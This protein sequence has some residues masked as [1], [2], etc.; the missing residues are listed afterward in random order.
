M[1]K[2]LFIKLGA[3]GDV[4]MALTALQRRLEDIPQEISWVCGKTVEPLIH[5]FLPSVN[6]FSLDE[7]KLFQA[8]PMKAMQEIIRVNWNLKGQKFDRIVVGYRDPRYRLFTLSARSKIRKFFTSIP[9]KYHAD[10]YYELLGGDA[11]KL[12][13]HPL[14]PKSLVPKAH[15]SQGWVIAPGGAKNIQRDDHLRR[16]PIEHYVRLTKLILD[17]KK[18]VTVLGSQTDE[19]VRPFFKNLPVKWA[20]GTV[21]LVD[22]PLWLQQFERLVTH[23]SGPMHLGFM[24]GIPVTALF[25]PT[26]ADEKVPKNAKENGSVIIQGGL[27]LPCAPCYDGRNYA[28]C[29]HQKC[30]AEVQPDW[31]TFTAT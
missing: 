28:Q 20:L 4:V 15:Q 5:R 3:I 19:W 26:R 11:Q 17:K 1:E 31:R 6:L 9:G 16:Y 24:A 18:E 14:N 27:G 12:I 29:E 10:I 8:S 22:L 30:L 25:G 13:T 7:Q 21:S 23:D 2:I